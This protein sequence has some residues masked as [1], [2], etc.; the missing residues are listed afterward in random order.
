MKKSLRLSETWFNRGLWLVALVFASF[1]IGLGGLVVRDLPGIDYQL[2]PNDFIDEGRAS[3]LRAQLEK[4]EQAARAAR[5]EQQQA[6]LLRDAAQSDSRAN[7]ESFSN[8]I[9]TRQATQQAGQDSELI[10]R[11]RRLDEL[12]QRELGAIQA[13]ESQD[14][15]LLN[16]EQ[17]ISKSQ[18]A[19]AELQAQANK[20]YEV[21]ARRIEMRVFLV[22]LA[23]TLP[24]LALAG[25]L[26][27]RKRKSPYWPFVWGFIF[28]AGFAF[29]VEL[30][31]YLPSYGGYVRYLVG[32]ALTALIGRQAIVS[33]SRYLEKQRAAEQLSSSER[34]QEL[35]YDAALNLLGKGV[36]PGCERGVDLKN[37]S[38]DFCPHC[39]MGLFCQCANCKTR[40]S[41]FTR[42]CHGCGQA[43]NAR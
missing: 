10:A 26:F 39:G 8:W 34:Q 11:T 12:K 22:R 38:I 41:T 28:F 13:L 40:K 21:Q 27:V 3:P 6:R 9:A 4:A 16:A 29:F 23:I 33:L 25:W 5:M 14:R 1:L 17:A 15:A 19:L 43:G 42:F 18:T 35:G 31:P 20:R 2:Q 30:V 24:L 7:A 32:I 36:C 37:P